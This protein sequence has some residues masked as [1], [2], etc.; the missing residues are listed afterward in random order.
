VGRPEETEHV[1]DPIRGSLATVASGEPLD[2]AAAEAFM[3]AVLDGEVT[4][5]Q[6]A[7][8]LMGLRVRGEEAEELT[9]FVRAM[10]SRAIAVRAPDGTIDIC[11]TG[12]DVHST[13]N[14][15]TAASIV[16]AAA[17]V[18]IAKAGNRAVSSMAGSS[19]VM[20][21]LGLTV[22]QGP[23]DAEAS[24]RDEGYAYLHAPA[25]HPGMRHAGPV[26]K[27][28]GVRTAFNLIGPIANPAR[29][30]RQLMG[31]PD[32]GSAEKAA[33][34]LRALGS[35]RAFV[36]TGDRI[37]EL[38]LDDSGVIFDVSGSGIV[39]IEVRAADHGL[40][41]AATEELR[42]GDAAEN[43]AAIEAIF[44]GREHGPR[45]DVVLLNSGAALV[46]AGTAATIREGVVLAA[47][48]I[49]TGAARVLLDRLRERA[50]ARAALAA[51]G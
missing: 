28:L 35:E 17:G 9:G 40:P 33:A 30:R 43:A 19:D 38:P 44:D 22:E 31:V 6:L 27:D 48:V 12:G 23:E 47:D 4:P 46:V 32:E 49:D 37:D 21:A 15:S 39:R 5:A 50:R 3:A 11:G 51:T 8:M 10:R 1:T 45:R 16:T 41:I 36:V 14:V 25:F 34:T 24:L 18:P 29:P 42:G 2:A 7:A 26:R 20:G 13:F